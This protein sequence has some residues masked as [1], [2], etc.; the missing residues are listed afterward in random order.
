MCSL[1]A[2]KESHYAG[3]AIAHFGGTACRR[4]MILRK[5]RGVG[6]EV[7]S[8]GRNRNDCPSTATRC[9]APAAL[10]LLLCAVSTGCHIA[11]RQHLN[12]Q[13]ACSIIYF[14]PG[15]VWIHGR[16]F[17]DMTLKTIA[18]AANPTANPLVWH[19]Q[20]HKKESVYPGHGY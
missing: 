20:L 19:H 10:E 5:D 11:G 9:A 7:L 4:G 8:A 17:R 13:T 18:Q 14:A 1:R 15:G 6:S 3:C 2:V 12:A 16:H